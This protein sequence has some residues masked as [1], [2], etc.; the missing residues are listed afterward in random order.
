MNRERIQLVKCISRLSIEFIGETGFGWLQCVR[1]NWKT[2]RA[3][4]WRARRSRWATRRTCTWRRR[5]CSVWHRRKFSWRSACCSPC[6]FQPCC[7]PFAS[8]CAWRAV[9]TRSTSN[10]CAVS[11][12]RRTITTT[13]NNISSSSS[14]NS[15]TGS[16]RRINMKHYSRS[17]DPF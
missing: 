7:S 12:S 4:R 13:T 14:S 3:G 17:N 15:R 8:A 1:R 16:R 9:R 10:W 11:P 5:P 6:S 2:R